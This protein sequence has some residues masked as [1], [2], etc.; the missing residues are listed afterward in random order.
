MKSDDK[1]HGTNAG[2]LMH[3]R[4]DKNACDD[5]RAA[6]VRYEKRRIHD[7]YKGQPR[8]IDV[9]GTRRR[10]QALV[11]LGWT[12]RAIGERAGISLSGV[13]KAINRYTVIRREVAAK[14]AAV[15]DELSMTLPPMDTRQQKRDANYARTVARKNGYLPPLVWDD[16]TI[17][18]PDAK[19]HGA[20]YVAPDRATRLADLDDMHAGISEACAR[21]KLSRDALEKWCERNGMSDTYSRMVARETS[22]RGFT[23][24]QHREA[25]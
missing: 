22:G 4:T 2:Y 13:H 14:Y 20:G 23:G 8:L 11:A 5:C 19:P 25:S 1:R 21:L 12:Y 16:A 15:Y 24:N 17:D 7:N 10:L 3:Q 6:H 18:D 9:T